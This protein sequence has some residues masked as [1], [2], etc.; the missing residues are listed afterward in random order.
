MTKISDCPS[1]G[2]RVIIRIA[3]TVFHHFICIVLTLMCASY[4]ESSTRATEVSSSGAEF[5]PAG[6]EGAVSLTFDDGMPSQLDRAVPT[7]DRARLKATFYVTPGY[8]TDWNENAERWARLAA[9]GH[10]LANHTDTHPC[11]CQTDFRHGGDYCLEKLDIK[12]VERSIDDAERALQALTSLPPS[13][14]SFAYP[15]NNT[16]VGAGASRKSYVPEVARRYS[17]ARV[18]SNIDNDP[19]TVDLSYVFAFMAESRTADQ[20]IAEIENSLHRGHWAVIVFHGIGAEW[21]VMDTGE[22]D[23]LM[24]YLAKN[25][26]R[27]WIAPFVEVARY[28]RLH[29]PP[30]YGH[31][32]AYPASVK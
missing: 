8:S 2:E 26:R 9:H 6:V 19:A 20:L 5:W 11:S 31:L 32:E 27:I 13:A 10:E 4:L 3:L 21:D 18:G 29:R 7:L 17:A 30:I 25:R 16:D 12:E 24:E 1:D 15:C 22:F 23:R 14:R 28:I